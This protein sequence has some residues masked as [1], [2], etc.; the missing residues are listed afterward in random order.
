MKSLWKWARRLL[1][2]LGALV[3]LG[4]L[5]GALFFRGSS[6][7]AMTWQTH[8][9]DRGDMLDSV[10]ATGS[11]EPLVTI[12]VGSQVGGKV[13][14]VY[15][16]PND[17]VKAGQP[18]ALLDT[19]LLESER[20]DRTITLN[21]MRAALAAFTSE[22]QNLALRVARNKLGRERVAT[23]VERYKATLDIQKKNLERYKDLV[24]ADAASISDLDL[25]RLEKENAERDLHLQHLDLKGQDLDAKQVEIDLKSL[26]I[27]EAQV[28]SDVEQAEQALA[29]AETNLKYATILS[30]IEGVVLERSVDPG[31]TLQAN[32]QTPNVFKIASNL[33][34]VRVTVQMDEAQ[35]G[36][37]REGQKATFQVD[38]WRG[39]KFE[40]FVKAVRLLHEMKANLVTYPVQIEADNLA[41]DGCQHGLLRPGMTAYVIIELERKKNALR[42]PAA[43]LRFVPPESARIEAAPPAVEAEAGKGAAK[44]RSDGLSATVYLDSGNG[45]LRAVLVQVGA[46]SGEYYE[47]VSG[48]LKEG[49]AVVTG[50]GGMSGRPDAETVVMLE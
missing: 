25:K 20:K 7:A 19:E 40:G 50:G 47:L 41:E 30:P 32:F 12:Q 22:R 5:S 16:K 1:M 45:G 28:C 18:L 31:Q 36:R 8:K 13:K 27:R 9:L 10:N 43:A 35:V 42:L 46:S 38:A 15:V 49:D 48:A 2:S 33:L 4:A 14:E 44:D 39:R 26:D 23:G 24:S 17:S 29:K 11:V 34:R 21:R 37:V 3:V 6:H